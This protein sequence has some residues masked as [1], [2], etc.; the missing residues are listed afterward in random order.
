MKNDPIVAPTFP[1][2]ILWS[3]VNHFTAVYEDKL[4]YSTHP[5]ILT[6]ASSW[7][8]YCQDNA[9]THIVITGLYPITVCFVICCPG[10]RV[11]PSSGTTGDFITVFVVVVVVAVN[12]PFEEN[13]WSFG[14]KLLSCLQ[15]H[16]FM[17][18]FLLF[19]FL[20]SL[21]YSSEAY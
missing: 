10:T 15:W 2:V 14:R 6:T 21:A 8:T 4:F 5:L 7:R 16:G 19:E 18:Q 20:L 9:K 11:Q 1:E 13:T 17:S 12:K 3:Q